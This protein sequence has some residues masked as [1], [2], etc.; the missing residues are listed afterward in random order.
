MTACELIIEDD[1]SSHAW[2]RYPLEAVCYANLSAFDGAAGVRM[3]LQAGFDEPIS[4]PISPEDFIA[5]IETYRPESL[6][7]PSAAQT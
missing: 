3:A 4:K 7:R 5:Q 1:A 2:V 6:R